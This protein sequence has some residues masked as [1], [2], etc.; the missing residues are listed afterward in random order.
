MMR[1]A[2]SYGFFLLDIK[3]HTPSRQMAESSKAGHRPNA[4]TY[5]LLRTALLCIA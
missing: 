4:V 3:Q 5:M 2:S 1:F